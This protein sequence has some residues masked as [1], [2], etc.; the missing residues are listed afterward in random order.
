VDW[1][2]VGLGNPGREY[3][4]TRH[5]VGFAVIERL[6]A[7][8]EIGRSRERYRGRLRE[9]RAGPTERPASFMNVCG[10]SSATRGPL[11]PAR[12]SRRR[13]R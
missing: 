6:A 10:S 7:Q 2:V 12:P 9:G 8:W 1:L 11:G 13:P 5:N 4:G 3:E